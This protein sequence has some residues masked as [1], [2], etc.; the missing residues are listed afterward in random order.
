[1]TYVLKPKEN[2]NLNQVAARRIA[3]NIATIKCDKRTVAGK[4]L[5]K[6]RTL[7]HQLRLLFEKHDGF[8]NV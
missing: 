2:E 5:A 8:R 1:M 7:V 6:A 3:E 4:D